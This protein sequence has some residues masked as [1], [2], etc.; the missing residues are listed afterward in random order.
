MN[1]VQG[2]SRAQ[3]VMQPGRSCASCPKRPSAAAPSALRDSALF[4]LQRIDGEYSRDLAGYL[5]AVSPLSLCCCQFLLLWQLSGLRSA[6]HPPV[7]VGQ[8]PIDCDCD[9]D[10]DATAPRPLNSSQLAAY[11]LPTLES[12]YCDQLGTTHMRMFVPEP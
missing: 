6:C 11:G 10:C 2:K 9:C 5:K 4:L 7:T 3:A 8:S 1:E 12:A